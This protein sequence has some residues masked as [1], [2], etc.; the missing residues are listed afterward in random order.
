MKNKRFLLLPMIM[1]IG[2]SC[3][4]LGNAPKSPEIEGNAPHRSDQSSS[5]P[6]IPGFE[7]STI[8]VPSIGQP[9]SGSQP[10]GDEVYPGDDLFEIC[11]VLDEESERCDAWYEFES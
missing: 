3:E 5:D 9:E 6:S 7:Q 8:V 11:E 4:D 1:M 10:E 2:A